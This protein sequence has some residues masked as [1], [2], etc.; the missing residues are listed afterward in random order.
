V[1][2]EN[3]SVTILLLI[4][5]VIINYYSITIEARPDG[6]AFAMWPPSAPCRPAKTL[7]HD[8]AFKYLKNKY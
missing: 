8:A 2:N 3:K 6:A 5:I 7:P 1:H 4:V